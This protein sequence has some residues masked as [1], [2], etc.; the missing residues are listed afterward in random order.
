MLAITPHLVF[1]GLYYKPDNF[2]QM[3]GKYLDTNQIITATITTTFIICLNGGC[4]GIYA[5]ISQRINPIT[6][7][8]ITIV[9]NVPIIYIFFLKILNLF[10]KYKVYPQ[11][12]KLF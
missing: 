11:L 12:F 1:I 5:F 2:Y 8:T 6:K 10:E 4:S 9:T 7:S 3:E